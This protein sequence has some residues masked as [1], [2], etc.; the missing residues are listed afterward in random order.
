[1]G[2]DLPHHKFNNYISQLSRIDLFLYHLDD[3]ELF[4]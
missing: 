1:M 4:K 3:I 2:V